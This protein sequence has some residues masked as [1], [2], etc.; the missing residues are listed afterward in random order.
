MT[1]E[2]CPICERDYHNIVNDVCPNCGFDF[3]EIKND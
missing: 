3:G 2:Y 1:K